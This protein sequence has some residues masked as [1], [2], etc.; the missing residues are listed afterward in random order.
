M[1][2]IDV[3]EQQD[4]F[5]N[6]MER[7]TP[8]DGQCLIKVRAIGVNRADLLQRAGKYP[9]PPGES[10]II[11][12]EVCG[13]VV[14]I[15]PDVDKSIMRSRVFGLVAGGGYAEYVV[16]NVKHILILPDNL[17]YQ[18]GAAIA[19][20]FLTAAQSLFKIAQLQSD[21]NVLIHAGASGVGSA[22]IQLAKV[23][24]ANVTV[25]VSG[26]LKANACKAL[27]ADNVINYKETDFV[28]WQKQHMASGFDVIVDVVGG[29]YL[30]R[31]INVSALDARIVIL[32]MLGGRFAEKVDVAK[33]LLKRIAVHASTLRN[34]SDAY[35]AELV[36]FL[37]EHF[38]GYF[39]SGELTPVIDKVFDWKDAESAHQLMSD[40]K[41]IGKIILTV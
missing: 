41:N 24:G 16:I 18:H 37:N 2:F 23:I 15:G 22:A 29:E 6:K 3:N 40:N 4:L 20:V 17:D 32:S 31:N 27:G 12:L 33:L 13:D 36:S 1:Q 39:Q 38:M 25:T 35:K 10:S 14:E 7:P 9:P 19:E 30:P 34:R 8:G 21:E 26:Q 28:A 11:G 5:F